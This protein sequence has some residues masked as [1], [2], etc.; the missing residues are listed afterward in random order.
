[1]KASM[2]VTPKDNEAAPKDSI[3]LADP[4]S[5]LDARDIPLGRLNVAV[6]LKRRMTMTIVRQPRL[7]LL[8]FVAALMATMATPSTAQQTPAPQSPAPQTTGQSAA[9]DAAIHRC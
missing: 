8:A 1:M 2:N 5:G 7:C 3:A 4:T 6:N 9:R